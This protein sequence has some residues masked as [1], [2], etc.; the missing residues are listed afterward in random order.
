MAKPCQEYVNFVPLTYFQSKDAKV[1]VA[2]TLF[3]SGGPTSVTGLDVS[4][5]HATA[6]HELLHQFLHENDLG[7]LDVGDDTFEHGPDTFVTTLGTLVTDKLS[8]ENQRAVTGSPF[9]TV[10][11]K[12]SDDY[13]ELYAFPNAGSFPA[14]AP[15]AA[16]VA[17]GLPRRGLLTLV[18]PIP[19]A[20]VFTQS[21]FNVAAQLTDPR[22]VVIPNEDVYILVG[23]GATDA[24]ERAAKTNAF[25]NVR[26]TVT[27]ASDLGQPTAPVIIPITIQALGANPD[28]KNPSR[29]GL[30]LSQAL[31]TFY[32]D[33]G[34]TGTQTQGSRAPVAITG[35]ILFSLIPV[36]TVM[37]AGPAITS[38]IFSGGLNTTEG[39][40][41]ISGSVKDLTSS[42]TVHPIPI[43]TSDFPNSLTLQFNGTTVTAKHSIQLDNGLVIQETATP[44]AGPPSVDLLSANGQ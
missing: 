9:A 43:G 36:L 4:S 38:Y 22:G 18:P 31:Q 5:A 28:S 35:K 44:V 1:I 16:L 3:R 2:G 12:Y 25:G 42:V 11:R 26:F 14:L 10:I 24:G 20:H 17:L 41:T 21:T 33:T 8:I 19:P 30:R 34:L 29:N 39:E 32:C 7:A 37:P 15:E 40:Y 23:A 6:I 27:A 13:A